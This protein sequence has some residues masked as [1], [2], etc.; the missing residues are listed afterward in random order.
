M[1]KILKINKFNKIRLNNRIFAM[2]MCQYSSNN[3][4]PSSWHYEHLSRLVCSNV[5]TVILESTAISKNGRITYKDLKLDNLREMKSFS[6]LISFLKKI[7]NIPIG[8]QISHSGRKGSS[9]VPWKKKNKPLKKLGWQT[10]AP[11]S[12][13]RANGWPLPKELKQSQ[14]NKIKKQFISSSILANKSGFDLL[15]IHMAHGYLLHQFLSPISNKRNDKYG[16]DLEN[17]MRLLIEIATEVRKIWPKSKI[18]GARICG[19]DCLKDGLK[20]NDTKILVKNLERIG[21]NYISISNGGIK[22]VTN[23]KIVKGYNLNT[24]RKLKQDTKLKVCVAGGMS[25]LNMANKAIKRNYC[26]FIGLAKPLIEDNSI[27]IREEF[28]K[29]TKIKKQYLRCFNKI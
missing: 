24:A 13:K 4:T 8:I 17:R 6:K 16:G 29:N 15:E 2:P 23:L 19:D 11:S 27:I 25:D 7:K 21:F 22:P 1:V 9:E 28:K 20:V 18:L 14:I 12:I 10:Y 3:G 5:S 26:D